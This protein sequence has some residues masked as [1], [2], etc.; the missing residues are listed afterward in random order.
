MSRVLNQTDLLYVSGHGPLRD[1]GSLHTGKVGADLDIADDTVALRRVGQELDRADKPDQLVRR[2]GRQIGIIPKRL[3]L[4]VVTEELQETDREQV[5]GRL[6]AREDHQPEHRRDLIVRDMARVL[7]LDHRGDETCGLVRGPLL[8]HEVL[9]VAD[10]TLVGRVGLKGHL[11][12][13]GVELVVGNRLRPGVDQIEV[14]DVDAEKVTDDPEREGVG[15]TLE[16][17]RAVGCLQLGEPLLDALIDAVLHLAL[18]RARR[19]RRQHGTAQ[20]RMVRRIHAD[21]LAELLLKDGIERLLLGSGKA[22]LG[23]VVHRGIARTGPAVL[24]VVVTE[25]LLHVL[26]AA[27]DNTLGH[28]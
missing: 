4:I 23:L 3:P 26:V 19:E 8:R 18:E 10:Q 13:V 15:E 28:A 12:G 14:L 21:Q 7:G 20:P 27:Q 11:P 1:D 16:V 22:V 2:L 24:L 25:Q 6:V 17:H 5:A 9:D